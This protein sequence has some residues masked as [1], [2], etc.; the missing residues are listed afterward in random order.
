[1][2]PCCGRYLVDHRR[3]AGLVGH[4]A[5]R[6]GRAPP[7]AGDLGGGRVGGGAVDVGEHHVRA[8]GRER[9]PEGLAEAAAAAG[10]H[11][12]LALMYLVGHL[13]L[14]S[15]GAEKTKPIIPNGSD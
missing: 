1:M 4:V 10:D 12:H 15:I 2:P 3:D 6:P 13:H 5:G 14:L 7:L 9:G 8:P 11:R